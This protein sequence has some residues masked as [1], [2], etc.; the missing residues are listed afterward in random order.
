MSKIQ[1]GDDSRKS[2]TATATPAVPGDLLTLYCRFQSPTGDTGPPR[3]KQGFAVR[4]WLTLTPLT[5]LTLP[6]PLV[7][8]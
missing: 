1:T 8:L 2:Q 5:P 6:T 7:S 3:M 4:R